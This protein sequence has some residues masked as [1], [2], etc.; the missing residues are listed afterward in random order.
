MGKAVH[1]PCSVEDESVTEC[2]AYEKCVREGFIP[3]VPRY[4][5]GDY[6]IKEYAE[7]LVVSG[8]KI[9]LK[10]Y[11]FLC[12]FI[13]VSHLLCWLY[14]NCLFFQFPLIHSVCH[15]NFAFA[16]NVKCST[17]IS[18]EHLKI[19]VVYGKFGGQTECIMGHDILFNKLVAGSHPRG[20]G[21]RGREGGRLPREVG[22][23]RWK[24][25]IICLKVRTI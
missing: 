6:N 15:P 14:F 5:G 18:Q 19:I 16:V 7:K 17:Q 23:A 8:I 11:Y 24:Q 21:A 22:D 20:A 2:E 1:W 13:Y 4:A 9:Q 25:W 3:K 10:Y 12:L